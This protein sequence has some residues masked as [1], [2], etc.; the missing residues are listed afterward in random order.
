MSAR[1]VLLGLPGTGK[2]SVGRALAARW[3]VEFLDT[4]EILETRE[5]VSAATLMRRDGVEIFRAKELDVLRDALASD[6]VVATGGGVVT[7]PAAR[8][9]L[10][11]FRCVWLRAA[12]RDLVR[13]VRGGDR[14]LLEGG[15]RTK[16]TQLADERDPFYEQLATYEVDAT[17]AIDDVVTAIC[18][19]VG[20]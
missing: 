11:S 13:R 7:T 9:L 5:A 17:A 14:P 1:L 16:L 3:S 20:E 18:H 12:P 4:D 6:A 15:A 8:E 10:R 2:S 19:L